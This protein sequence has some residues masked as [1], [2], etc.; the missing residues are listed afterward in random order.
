MALLL[1][2]NKLHLLQ[3][4][5]KFYLLNMKNLTKLFLF[6]ALTFVGLSTANAQDKNN[7]WA[8]SIGV[9]AVD[10]YPVYPPDN[11]PLTGGFPDEYFNVRDHWNI[12]PS[13]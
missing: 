10:T 9:N 11:R 4:T 2:F 12:L 13:D 6:A 1:D 3:L 7:P 8:I 5:L